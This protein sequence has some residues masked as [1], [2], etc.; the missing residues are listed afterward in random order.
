MIKSSEHV[1]DKDNYGR[2]FFDI[3]TIKIPKKIKVSVTKPH[4]RI[5]VDKRTGLKFSY[6]F[7]ANN[8]MIEP[9]C[10]QLS[11]C[12]HGVQPVRL[13]RCKNAGDNFN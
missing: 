9:T 12:R 3:S 11:K 1:P 13:T 7:Q 6:L 2:I 5:M 4:W 10:V 8:Y